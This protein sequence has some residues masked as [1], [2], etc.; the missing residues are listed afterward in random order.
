VTIVTIEIIMGIN[1]KW[2]YTIW[3][4]KKMQLWKPLPIETITIPSTNLGENKLGI[5]YSTLW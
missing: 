1:R 5:V 4:W 2:G 3:I